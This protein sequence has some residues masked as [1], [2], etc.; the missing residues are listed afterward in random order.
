MAVWQPKTCDMPG[1]ARHPCQGLKNRLFPYPWAA[2]CRQD[3]VTLESLRGF[4]HLQARSDRQVDYETQTWA[5]E[6]QPRPESKDAKT[7]CY[8]RGR[9]RIHQACPIHNLRK[10]RSGLACEGQGSRAC[11]QVGVSGN[12]C[13]RL[14]QFV[15]THLGHSAC[16]QSGTKAKVRASVHAPRDMHGPHPRPQVPDWTTPVQTESG[17]GGCC[18][19]AKRATA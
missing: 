7:K 17:R 15:H 12:R 5:A 1:R 2:T 14:N 13:A 9:L 18:V 4:S 16:K 19:G 10:G 3:R 6:V 8:G 11:T